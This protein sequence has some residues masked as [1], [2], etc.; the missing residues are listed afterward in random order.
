MFA[1][2]VVVLLLLYIIGAKLH[3]LGLMITGT[4]DIFAQWPRLP[5][6]CIVLWPITMPISVIVH[7]VKGTR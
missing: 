4:P 7:L 5:Y 2:E 6:V 3:S 1:F